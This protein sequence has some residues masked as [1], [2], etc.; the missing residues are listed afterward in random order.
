MLVNRDIIIVG[1][2]AWD[3]EIGSNCKNIAEEFSKNNRVL[4]VNYPLDRITMF[5]QRKSEKVRKRIQIFKSG[6]AELNEIS[7]NLWNL[8]PAT[9]LESINWISIARLYDWLNKTNNKRFS[10][11]IQWAIGQLGFK[12]YLIFND[13]D[14]LRSFYLKELLQPETYVYYTR[15][16]LIS[17]DYWKRQGVRLEALHM[18]KADLVVANSTYLATLARKYNPN[19]F[20]V[21]QGCDVSLFDRQRVQSIPSDIKD[22]PKPVIGYIGALISLR[23]DI[24]VLEFIAENRPKWSLVLVG[25]EDELFKNS[26]LHH[27]KNVYFLGNKNGND[28]PAYLNRFDVALNPQIVSPMTIGNYPRKIDEY[29]A[30]GKP[31]VATQTEAMS[32]FADHAY[33]AQTK[34]E[35]IDLIE[36]ALEQDN[37]QVQLRR[38]EFARQHTWENNVVEI[39][40]AIEAVKAG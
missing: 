17:T 4:Y 14:M 8:Y 5:R 28:L 25:P 19:S 1:I 7:S 38:E 26:R 34:E 10:R 36:K 29:L 22:V 23:L 13:S 40:R 9:V 27:F 35:Y 16:N 6:K 3:I 33:L 11:Q 37:E 24:Q 15:D 32:A 18:K 20:Y 39:Y 31:T 21:G 2:Q 12:N 30:M